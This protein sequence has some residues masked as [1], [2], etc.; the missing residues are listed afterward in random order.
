MAPPASGA[1]QPGG[2][3]E[4][5]F[6]PPCSR[7][8]PPTTT[9]GPVP[10][11]LILHHRDPPRFPPRITSRKTPQPSRPPLSLP[12]LPGR[13]CRSAKLTGTPPDD[14][15]SE[16]HHP[17]TSP[18]APFSRS[19]SRTALQHFPAISAHSALHRQ[20]PGS[21]PQPS[22][23]LHAI[24]RPSRFAHLYF[25]PTQAN[26]RL[27]AATRGRPTSLRSAAPPF[28]VFLTADCH[29]SHRQPLWTSPQSLPALSAILRPS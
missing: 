17:A 27:P 4:P 6:A 3:A 18:T 22:A 13:P 12:R 10:H 25:T 16:S 9:T 15:R 11:A 29:A 5:L 28:P 8:A 21:L 20:P 26:L 14:P 24:P 1:A 2:N 19:I 7:H 23:T